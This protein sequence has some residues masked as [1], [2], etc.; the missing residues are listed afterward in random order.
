MK[1]KFLLLILL[2]TTI[3]P[4]S[5][6]IWDRKV[7]FYNG[8]A[9]DFEIRESFT[10]GKFFEIIDVEG[11]WVYS[12]ANGNLG[13]F[14]IDEVREVRSQRKVIGNYANVALLMG[15]DWDYDTITVI[16]APVEVD[17]VWQEN[18]FAFVQVN[19]SGV[20]VYK[21]AVEDIVHNTPIPGKTEP[22]TEIY[23]G[24]DWDDDDIQNPDIPVRINEVPQTY[25]D[26]GPHPFIVQTDE[27]AEYPYRNSRDNSKVYVQRDSDMPFEKPRKNEWQ[28]RQVWLGAGFA[29][30]KLADIDLEAYRTHSELYRI[31]Q[32]DY[33]ILEDEVT[34]L[35]PLS[36]RAYYLVDEL[37]SFFDF[38]V[39]LA[40]HPNEN[41][42]LYGAE[43]ATGFALPVQ[44]EILIDT[45]LA[46]GYSW[47][48][49]K[50]KNVVDTDYIT[51]EEFPHIKAEIGISTK[52]F[53]PIRLA[54]GL[55]FSEDIDDGRIEFSGENED[56]IHFY[57][58]K[59]DTKID[60]KLKGPYLKIEMG[61]IP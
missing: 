50:Y 59:E 19:G 13:Y 33:G 51:N 14:Y 4:R 42:L 60:L 7:D 3:Y 1:Y 32:S 41:I 53:L 24:D 25:N 43:A 22:S 44:D 38:G 11:D 57:A 36:L 47:L 10:R 26:T 20:W 27:S 58:D 37:N 17:Y 18:D 34:Y 21:T 35:I 39:D 55:R 45:R 5:G 52:P 15:P 28:Y 31:Q 46:F 12:R 29:G 49:R 6:V 48:H 23:L 30:V 56:N 2:I 54:I 8:P 61:L 40:F 9:E 16:N